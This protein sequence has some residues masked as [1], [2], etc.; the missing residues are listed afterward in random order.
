MHKSKIMM[1]SDSVL[2][3][4]GYSNQTMNILNRLTNYECHAQCHN[5]MGQS[6]PPG[7]KLKDG[8]TFDFWIHGNGSVP[9]SQDLLSPRIKELEIDIFGVLLDT[10]MCFPW[11]IEKD[12]APAKTF[13]YFPTDGEN[14][15]PVGCENI[16]RKIHFPVCM[17]KFGQEQCAVKYGINV[18]HIPHGVDSTVFKPLTQSKRDTLRKEQTVYSLSNHQLTG[19]KGALWGKYVIGVVARNQGRKMLD[20]T[21][22]AMAILKEK[23]P[24]AVLFMHSDPLDSA[25]VFDMELIMK[26]YKLQNRVFFSGMNFYKGFEHSEMNDMYNL[27]DVFYLSTSGEGFGIPIIEAMSAGV[28][29]IVTDYTTTKELIIDNGQCGEAVN[30]IG[31]T[32]PHTNMVYQ[33]LTNGTI[34]GNW[35]VERGVCDIFD[36]AKKLEKLTDIKLRK[37]YAKIGREKV[38]KI[39]DWKVV[40]KQWQAFFKKIMEA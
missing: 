23:V 38:L 36:A 3:S 17:S 35:G 5:Y 20:R 9:Y 1:L 26:E 30:L 39:Y 11:L 34:L 29:P 13:F 4:T 18:D 6:I 31:E 24:N 8:T 32:G 14:Q 27:M 19:V 25:S 10:F 12:L 40:M 2:T 21:F 28:P 33:P 16:L 15:M 22:K 37:K 7:L